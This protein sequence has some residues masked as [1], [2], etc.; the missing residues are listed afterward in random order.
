M[1]LTPEEQ[2]EL[3]ELQAGGGAPPPPP[4]RLGHQ[5]GRYAMNTLQSAGKAADYL[6]S[7]TTG[8]LT[9]KAIEMLTGKPVFSTDELKGGVNPTNLNRFPTNSE[10]FERAGLVNPK[11]SDV[12]PGYADPGSQHPWYQP[13]KGGMLDPTAAGTLQ[14]V[15]DPAMWLGAGEAGEAA[16]V[17][18]QANRAAASPLGKLNYWASDAT[19]AAANAAGT[20][21]GAKPT[22]AVV[23]AI[24][25]TLQKVPGAGG[26]I[27]DANT[28]FNPGSA[29]LRAGGKTLY[30]SMLL[31]VEHE[32]EAYGKSAVGDT[33]YKSGIASPLGL[34]EK[35]QNAANALLGRRGQIF[36]EAADKGATVDMTKALEPGFAQVRYLRSLGN[37]TADQVANELENELN[38]TLTRANG[39]PAIPGQPATPGV[40]YTPVEPG[41]IPTGEFGQSVP[42]LVPS[43]PVHYE[44]P[45][46]QGV[47]G[48]PEV[49]AQPYTPQKASDLKSFL[50]DTVGNNGY[51]PNL[52]TPIAKR[53]FKNSA[54]G[55]KMAIEDSVG[56]ALGPESQEAVADLN[57]EASKLLATQKAQTVVS[58]GADR[59]AYT[60][61][62]I[63]SPDAMQGSLGYMAGGPG[64]ASAA[65]AARKLLETAGQLGT[66]PLGYGLR[67]LGDTDIVDRLYP[68]PKAS[69]WNFQTKENK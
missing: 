18:A 50:T 5:L 47:P 39:R 41:L 6:R 13:E 42:G 62:E 29:V 56:Q 11:L 37:E 17:L 19:K 66:M 21:T 2:L 64:G 25:Q 61:L 23:D 22:A 24:T 14:V 60:P 65:I 55:I 10:M 67:A 12:V 54:G 3:E 58:H 44:I 8:P 28:I 30:N 4:E 7:G 69:P 49:P 1:A 9:G 34:R 26:Y 52:S 31:P 20:V 53:G 57:N 33:L 43:G 32:G 40:G 45:P 35:A 36:Q 27:P 59:A 46:A 16:D 51:K 48:V 38:S 63:G 15:S 68:H